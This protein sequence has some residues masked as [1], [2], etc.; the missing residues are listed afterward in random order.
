M[1]PGLS[2]G[3]LVKWN[4]DRGFGF[5]RSGETGKD[6][7]LHISEVKTTGRRPKVGDII[8]YR[9]SQGADGKVRATGAS[10]QGVVS[11]S[12]TTQ[13]R[14]PARRMSRPA[15]QKAKK[16]TLLET[17][18]TIGAMGIIG[19]LHSVFFTSDSSGPL[20]VAENPN[21]LVKG[22]ISISS[23]RKLYHLPGMK[24]YEETTIYPDEGERWFCSEA[25]AI[26]AG[27]TK[28]PR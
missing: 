26:A 21:C 15:R 2:K 28:A 22:N 1:K 23:G 20:T 17:I 24:D 27:W 10:I 3:P 19:F 9:L 13:T 12:A 5:I 18:L 16:N 14:R 11:R 7:F 4:D 6:V 25:D 8:F